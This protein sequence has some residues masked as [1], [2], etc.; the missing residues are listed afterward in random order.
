[1]PAKNQRQACDAVQP[2]LRSVIVIGEC[3]RL[4]LPGALFELREHA[5]SAKI[6]S[7][8]R[9]THVHVATDPCFERPI[10]PEFDGA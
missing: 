2:P 5:L 1:M 8:S 9:N 4:N 10:I 6:A 3:A 7:A